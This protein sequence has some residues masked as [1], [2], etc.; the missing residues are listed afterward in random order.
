MGFTQ[1][2]IYTPNESLQTTVSMSAAVGPT[3]SNMLKQKGHSRGRALPQSAMKEGVE[4]LPRVNW[5]WP[6]IN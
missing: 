3:A 5:V 1:G 2:R 6:H 4:I